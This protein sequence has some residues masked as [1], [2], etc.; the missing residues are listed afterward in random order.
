MLSH[1]FPV[2]VA[3]HVE[4]GTDGLAF[5]KAFAF[6]GLEIFCLST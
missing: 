2:P 3:L 4:F 6:I 1:V 5:E